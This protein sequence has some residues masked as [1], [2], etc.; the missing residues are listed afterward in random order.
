MS[1]G[2]LIESYGDQSEPGRWAVPRQKVPVNFR[3]QG[4]GS[5]RHFL[6]APRTPGS[7]LVPFAK[8]SLAF[9]EFGRPFIIV[10]VRVASANARKLDTSVARSR[11]PS[12]FCPRDLSVPTEPTPPIVA[13]LRSS[14]LPRV[15]R[16]KAPRAGSVASRPKRP[17]SRPPSPSRAPSA[18][19]SALRCAP[20]PGG[21]N[22]RAKPTTAARR[23]RASSEIAPPP[24]PRA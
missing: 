6:V 12:P 1:C 16:S 21:S 19:L 9:D 5:L 23:R 3:K 7:R 14:P 20:S 15:N 10:K 18:L 17:T 24:E 11:R 13:H 8:M 2:Q 4:G 22:T